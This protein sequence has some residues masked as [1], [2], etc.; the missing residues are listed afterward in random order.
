M[1]LFRLTEI[2]AGTIRLDGVDV[3]KIGTDDLRKNVAIIPQ[4]P[5]LF[6]GTIRSNLDPIKSVSLS[7]S[8]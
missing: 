6:S 3:S 5:V 8:L 7:R 4:D 1:A 2:F